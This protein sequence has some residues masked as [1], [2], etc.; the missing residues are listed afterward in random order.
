LGPAI[1]A[2]G[3]FV[4]FESDATNLVPDDTNRLTDGFVRDRKTGTTE[5]VSVGAHGAQAKGGSYGSFGAAISADGRYVAF[6]SD[7]TNLVP[8]DTNDLIDVFVHDRLT[9]TTERVS[10]ATGGGQATGGNYTGLLPS[11]SANGRFVAFEAEADNLVPNDTNFSRDVFVHDR[12]TGRTER[13][14]INSNGT[15]AEVGCEYPT[16]SATGRFVAF[17]TTEGSDRRLPKAR[18]P[19]PPG[20][21]L[22]SPYGI[23]LHDRQTGRTEEV[24]LGP[25]GARGSTA[26]VD[27]SG[28]SIAVSKDGR[29]VAFDTDATNLVEGDTN[30]TVDVFLRDRK[31]GRTKRIS[32][33]PGGVQGDGGSYAVTMSRDGRFLA[34]ASDATNLVKGDTNGVT[35]IFFRDLVTGARERVSVGPRGEQANNYS[36]DAAI[37]AEGRVVAFSSD[38][39]N[40]VPRDTNEHRDVFVHPR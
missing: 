38:A 18:R 36:Y 5:R 12:V 29:F 9:G 25:H 33:G 8:D 22:S 27:G 16:I 3:R 6:A 39:S 28:G 31:L 26:A 2:S 15:Q 21:L 30:D 37:S 17:A 19:S 23:F 32:V 11:I 20:G 14:S 4:A 35:D 24:D 40:L 10:V 1:S 34:F 13:V 7:D